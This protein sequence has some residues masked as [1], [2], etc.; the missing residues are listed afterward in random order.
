MSLTIM[1][2]PDRARDKH[3]SLFSHNVSE[4]KVLSKR[5][6]ALYYKKITVVIKRQDCKLAHLPFP[7]WG[8]FYK[9]MYVIYEFT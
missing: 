5:R 3:T 2:K 6:R 7:P 4:E 8:Q 1:N 9:K